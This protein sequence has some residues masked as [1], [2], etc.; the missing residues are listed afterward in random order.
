MAFDTSAISEKMDSWKKSEQNWILFET[1][2]NLK[3]L[4]FVGEGSGGHSEWIDTVD[5]AKIQFTLLRVLAVDEEGSRRTKF[6]FV[7]FVGAKVSPLKRA[8]VSVIKPEVQSAM[9]AIT[10]TL[11]GDTPSDFTVTSI[12]K[13]LLRCGGAHKPLY[14]DFFS[15]QFQTSTLNN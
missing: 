7:S 10:L 4:E 12:A 6:V 8:K 9:G 13:D 1:D 14:F 3:K 11:E 2:A 15:E 5:D